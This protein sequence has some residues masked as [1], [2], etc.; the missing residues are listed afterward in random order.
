MKDNNTSRAERGLQ[1]RMTL[2]VAGAVL[3][4]ATIVM[5]AASALLHNKL[6]EQLRGQLVEDMNATILVLDQHMKRVEHI[7]T[8]TSALVEEHI[9]VCGRE[10][11]D[12]MMYV[13]ALEEKSIDVVSVELAE[14]GDSIAT[15]YTAYNTM[16]GGERHVEIIPAFTE[17]LAGDDNWT[18]SYHHGEMLWWP[19]YVPERFPDMKLQCLS[20]PL[21]TDEGQRIG[22]VCAMILEQWLVEMVKKSKTRPDIDLSIYDDAGHCIVAPD[23]YILHLPPSDLITEE[24]TLER[25]GW[26]IVLSA[27][28]HIVSDKVNTT[29]WLMAAV[30]L[31]LLLSVAVAIVLTVRYVARPFVKQQQELA[32]A[33]AAMERELQIAAS[34]QHELV[35]HAFPPFP[36]HP[37]IS[38]HACLHPA[39]EVGGDLYDYFIHEGNLYFCLGDVSGKGLPASLFMSACHYL[40]RSVAAAMPMAEAVKQMN[41]SLCTD[42]AQ[43]NF[44]TF[45]F[46][47]LQ[48]ATGLLEYCNAG[49][50]PPILLSSRSA[51]FFA[52]SESTPLG[53]WDEEEYAAH[54]LQLAPNE[55]VL[56]YTD[57]VTEAKSPTNAE[58]GEEAT[59]RCAAQCQPRE[60][61][62]II[63]ALLASVRQHAATAPQSDDITMLCLS[64]KG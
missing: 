52:V 55:M 14:P 33:K 45:F 30:V 35:P 29:A 48:L 4:V 40:F 5:T 38:V 2:W 53:V 57:G 1:L 19:H 63:D 46:G 61:Q 60:P 7:A 15:M 12:S 3:I 25:F 59:L 36:Q 24:R 47:R 31:L 43:C 22:M 54:T 9:E 21:T 26:R 44:V 32:A 27:D 11:L 41:L 34:T 39:K 51:D 8:T 56:L 23:D 16:R 13:L 18:A 28:R 49:H 50:N 64:W 6:E 62:T 37:E 10:G 20:V 58:F 17:R 42:N